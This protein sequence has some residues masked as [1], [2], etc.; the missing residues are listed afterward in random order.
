M[1]TGTI[2][3]TNYATGGHKTNSVRNSSHQNGVSREYGLSNTNQ[4]QFNHVP[5]PPRVNQSYTQEFQPT[6]QGTED[7]RNTN[8]RKVFK[9]SVKSINHQSDGE[10]ESVER[11]N[12]LV[13][14]STPQPQRSQAKLKGY[15]PMSNSLPPKNGNM[16]GTGRIINNR[17]PP[18]QDRNNHQPAYNVM[19][20]T[21][22]PPDEPQ[23]NSNS[24][25]RRSR[26]GLPP[27]KEQVS[28]R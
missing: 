22:Y 14:G 13:M 17:P 3:N 23:P 4:G 12:A 26:Q 20:H 1:R 7:G 28:Q 11:A 2:E 19:D 5:R 15:E 10:Y 27:R 18:A 21:P 6:A 24:S 25:V 9:P 8:Y 16:H